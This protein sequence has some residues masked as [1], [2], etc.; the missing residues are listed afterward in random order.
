M[1][2]EFNWYLNRQGPRG[3]QGPQGEQGFSPVITV[4]ED[5]LNAYILR[6][7]TQDNNFLTSNLRGS[8]QDLGGTY[9]RYNRETGQLYAGSA[10]AANTEL[11][12]IVRLASAQDISELAQDV[13]VTPKD[14][15]ALVGSSDA[16]E[17]LQ[18]QINTNKAD[19]TNIQGNYVTTNTFQNI[20]ASKAFNNG[21][22]VNDIFNSNGSLVLSILAGGMMQFNT[23]GGGLSLNGGTLRVNNGSIKAKSIHQPSSNYEVYDVITSFD[24]A[25]ANT[26]G[27]VKPD[28]TTITVDT[29]GTMHGVSAYELPVATNAS[30]GGVKVGNNLT[31]AEDGTINFAVAPDNIAKLSSA[32]LFEKPAMF[33]NASIDMMTS[34]DNNITI[35]PIGGIYFTG[36]L[37]AQLRTPDDVSLSILSGGLTFN[38]KP[39]LT[40]ENIVAGENITITKDDTTGN[41]TISS[42]GEGSSVNDKY[43]IRGDYSTHFGILDC[44]NGLIDYNATGKEITLNAG[45]VLQLAGQEA[46]TTIASPIT[47]TLTSSTPITLFYGGGELLEVGQIDYSTT[48]PTDDGVDNY[49]AWFNPETGKWQFKSTETGNVWRELVATPIANINM[50][51]SNITRVDYIGYRIL[52]DDIIAQQSDIENLQNIITTLQ[53]T[54]ATLENRIEALETEING[55]SSTS[56]SNPTVRGVQSSIEGANYVNSKVN[57][58]STEIKEEE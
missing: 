19:I 57:K 20:T 53:Q 36:S 9:V 47:K 12:G 45:I 15:N 51:G 28:G 10:D 13:A 6:I 30:L 35:D 42:S 29:D 3:Q 41:V 23:L 11:A 5:S 33:L 27:V 37:A 39:V 14:V 40:T 56:P 8:V 21:L 55:G 18:K 1:T 32:N 44:P 7:Q 2:T 24:I 46:K 34:G 54:I 52:D 4:E 48:E 25:N 17:D 58:I 26:L 38:H 49:Q 16:V 31:V 50:N 43:G 22:I